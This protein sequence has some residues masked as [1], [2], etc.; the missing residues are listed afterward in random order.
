MPVQQFR[1]ATLLTLYPT[2]QLVR[3]FDQEF[4]YCKVHVIAHCR[5]TSG[6]PLPQKAR[7]Y[8]KPVF[9]P[10]S[11]RG[12]FKGRSPSSKDEPAGAT[13]GQ[14]WRRAAAVESAKFIADRVLDGRSGSNHRETNCIPKELVR[15]GRVTRPLFLY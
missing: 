5:V 1:C 4:T 10:S 7:C 12:R 6:N 9:Y 2:A 8:T 3:H 13:K 15:Y 14:L 11:C